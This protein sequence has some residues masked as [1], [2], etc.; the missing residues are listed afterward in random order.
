MSRSTIN[1]MLAVLLVLAGMGLWGLSGVVV[2]RAWPTINTVMHQP[3][4]ADTVQDSCEAAA[5]QLGFRARPAQNTLMLTWPGDDLS[6][7]K[8]AFD[9]AS[10]VI[11]LC[12]AHHTQSFCAG[13]DCGQG[14]LFMSLRKNWK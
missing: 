3:P 9:K 2:Y 14:I 8:G 10:L 1:I 4:P 12:D 13:P 6:Q 11:A 5:T 7:L